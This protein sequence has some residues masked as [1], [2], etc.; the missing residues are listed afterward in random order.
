M[1]FFHISLTGQFLTQM[2]VL[3][4]I[5][6]EITANNT[7]LSSIFLKVMESWLMVA[8][9]NQVDSKCQSA[10]ITFWKFHYNRS[11][12]TKYFLLTQQTDKLKGNYMIS[13]FS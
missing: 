2:L 8:I 9:L 6:L 10:V 12:D 11:G 3:P 4:Q 13:L 7:T 5:V 1:R